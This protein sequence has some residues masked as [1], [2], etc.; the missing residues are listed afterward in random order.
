MNQLFETVV[1][2]SGRV[3]W[4]AGRGGPLACG[5]C[6]NTGPHAHDRHDVGRHGVDGRRH[7][8]AR[9]QRHP[10]GLRRHA[11]DNAR[12][13]LTAYSIGLTSSSSRPG[14][15]P[16]ARAGAACSSSAP[17]CSCSAPGCARYAPSPGLLIAAR[18]SRAPVTRSHA[19][20]AGAHPRRVAP[21]AAHTGDRRM[22]HRGRHLV[23][24]RPA[25]GTLIVQH[26]S[27]RFLRVRGQRGARP[28]HARAALRLK[29]DT[30]RHADT[31]LPDP[32][33]IVLLSTTL[34]SSRS[35][36]VQGRTWGWGGR[37]S[38]AQW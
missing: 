14:A 4:N 29:I 38:S 13:D 35:V 16:T 34:T 20:V 9:L 28:A 36:I 5:S 25:L 31:L 1:R 12:V 22:D 7:D 3:W 10:Q 26:F 32:V 33:G 15:S 27:W 18:S 24:H 2:R 17:R 19:R 11:A 6:P 37:A 21:R 23:G 30:E 8:P